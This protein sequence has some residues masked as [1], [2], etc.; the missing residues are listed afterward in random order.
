MGLV[1]QIVDGDVLDAAVKFAQRFHHAPTEALG[2]A[3]SVMNHA[4]ESER[5]EVYALEAMAQAMAR[6]SDFH[7]DAVRRFI[8]KEPAAY[9]WV[10]D[11]NTNA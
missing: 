7:Q 6:E 9:Q 10:V 11:P 5:R 8:A 1:Q 2:I 3:K 4:F